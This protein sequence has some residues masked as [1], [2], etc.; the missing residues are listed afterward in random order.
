M[1]SPN[2]PIAT[3]RVLLLALASACT[4]DKAPPEGDAGT[5][6]GTDAGTGTGTDTGTD[7]GTGTACTTPIPTGLAGGWTVEHAG[8]VGT[9]RFVHPRNTD[10]DGAIVAAR[11]ASALGG[12]GVPATSDSR[13][14]ILDPTRMVDATYVDEVAAFIVDD[15]YGGVGLAGSNPL[16]DSDTLVLTSVHRHGLYVAEALHAPVLP[17]QFIAFAD[18]WAQ[19]EAASARATVIVGQDYDFDGLWLWNKLA[20][21]EPGTMAAELPEAY[22]RAVAAAE[23]LV[24]VQPDDNWTYCT[25]AACADAVSDVYSGADA[26]VYLHTSITRSDVVNTGTRLYAQARDVGL[27][28]PA[29]DSAVEN[30]KQWEWGVPDSTVDNVRALWESLGKP[31][32]DLIVI[33]G[34]VVD[35][36][37]ATPWLWQEYLAKNGLSAEGVHFLSYWAAFPALERCSAALP[38]PSYTW[39]TPDWHPLDDNARELLGEVCGA[40]CDTSFGA[41]TRVFVNTV[42]SSLDPDAHRTLLEDFG[43]GADDVWFGEGYNAR[44]STSWLGWEGEPVAFGWE[45]VADALVDPSA[46]PHADRAWDP[47]TP[48]ELCATA[49]HD[50]D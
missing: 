49:L 8:T 41:R 36:F 9:A 6:S 5:D 22:V 48:R 12:L 38:L 20:A 47:L 3:L 18:D 11:L 39:W 40:A 30:L 16:L 44:G 35:L 42:G 25:D 14:A 45:L 43:L 21:G 23:H 34:G 33:R 17:L 15:L 26:P 28:A 32:E 31:A 10:K 50:C 46:C 37:E 7:T 2:A 13:D 24:L 29:P 1:R 19:V 27:L 4:D